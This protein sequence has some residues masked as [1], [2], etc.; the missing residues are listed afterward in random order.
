MT[1]QER[2]QAAEDVLRRCGAGVLSVGEAQYWLEVTCAFRVATGSRVGPGCH[3]AELHDL[4]VH[5]DAGLS[6]YV[7]VKF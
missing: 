2:V 1:R 7:V 5:R 3:R 4:N 6:P